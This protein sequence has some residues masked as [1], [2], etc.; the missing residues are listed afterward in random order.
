MGQW[1]VGSL[2]FEAPRTLISLG[3]AISSGGV[4]GFFK[5]GFKK[6]IRKSLNSKGKKTAAQLAAD[7]IRRNKRN[8]VGKRLGA[9]YMGGSATGA[10]ASSF[11]NDV[12]RPFQA[13]FQP[14][15]DG[16]IESW[17]EKLELDILLNPF[18]KKA[19]AAGASNWLLNI[20]KAGATG[21][22]SEMGAEFGSNLNHAIFK[23][24]GLPRLNEVDE[25][26]ARNQI[27]EGLLEA[28]TLGFFMDAGFATAGQVGAGA[29]NKAGKF[30]Q[31]RI[32]AAN[33]PSKENIGN[34]NDALKDVNNQVGAKVAN[35]I[36]FGMLG[37]KYIAIE[38][39]AQGQPKKQVEVPNR[40]KLDELKFYEK[41]NELYKESEK[42]MFFYEE[43]ADGKVKLQATVYD[44]KLLIDFTFPQKPTR[45]GK[46]S[47]KEFFGTTYLDIEKFKK[48]FGKSGK[49]Y[50]TY[51]AFG[52]MIDMLPNTRK[53]KEYAKFVEK[54]RQQYKDILKESPFGVYTD[55]P[56]SGGFFS[57][58]DQSVN[59]NFNQQG[60]IT[61]ETI[62]H[63]SIHATTAPLIYRQLEDLLR[64]DEKARKLFNS[65]GKDSYKGI[66]YLSEKFPETELGQ[67][68]RLMVIAFESQGLD[69][70]ILQRANGTQEAASGIPGVP[71][72]QSLIVE[73]VTETI[74]SRSFQEELASIPMPGKSGTNLFTEFLNLLLRVL[75]FKKDENNLLLE[76]IGLV[77]SISDVTQDK[78]KKFR[79]ENPDDL[80]NA[81]GLP[82]R[83]MRNLDYSTDLRTRTDKEKESLRQRKERIYQRS[84][85]EK[86]RMEL[87]ALGAETLVDMIRNESPIKERAKANL[88]SRDYNVL[89][90]SKDVELLA[91]T[92]LQLDLQQNVKGK[93]SGYQ[94]IERGNF[95][96][97]PGSVV[98]GQR[99]DRR[100]Q[101]KPTYNEIFDNM[102]VLQAFGKPISLP[103]TLNKFKYNKTFLFS[104]EI[105]ELFGETYTILKSEYA[106]NVQAEDMRPGFIVLEGDLTVAD[107][108]AQYEQGNADG[109]VK[110]YFLDKEDKNIPS[111]YKDDMLD[112]VT[113]ALTL[114]E[115]LLKEEQKIRNRIDGV[116]T[117]VEIDDGTYIFLDAPLG[118]FSERAQA[119]LN[120]ANGSTKEGRSGFRGLARRI[121]TPKKWRNV[122][123]RIKELAPKIFIAERRMHQREN[124]Y[125][126]K[127][128]EAFRPF[129]NKFNQITRQLSTK[130]NKGEKGFQYSERDEFNA[131]VLNG[132]WDTVLQ[133]AK[134]KGI[135]ISN[136]IKQIQELYADIAKKLGFPPNVNYFRR[137][138]IDKDA[139]EAYIMNKPTSFIEQLWIRAAKRK[140]AALTT[141]EKRAVI[142]AQLLRGKNA[143]ELL[144]QR[145]IDKVDPF[146]SRFYA[147]PVGRQD[148][149]FTRAAR[150]FAR[151]EF[152]GMKPKTRTLKTDERIEIGKD[153]KGK[154]IYKREKGED[155]KPGPFV[156]QDLT[157]VN[158]DPVLTI[159]DS[160]MTNMVYDNDDVTSLMQDI[161]TDEVFKKLTVDDKNELTKLLKSVLN[162]QPSGKWGSRVRT[163]VSLKS[164]LQLDTILLQLVDVAVSM[165]YNGIPATV[166]AMFSKEQ[167]YNEV[168][169]LATLGLADIGIEAFDV[170]VAENR[171][172]ASKTF[173]GRAQKITDSTLKLAFAP[174]GAMDLF[175]KRTLAMATVR[176]WKD[177][178]VND[179]QTLYRILK[180]K[181]NDDA[182]IQKVI[183]DIANNKASAD[184]KLAF[185][186]EVSEY[187]PITTSDQIQYYIDNKAIRPALVLSSFAF[188]LYSRFG[189]QGIGLLTEGSALLKAGKIDSNE[190]AIEQGKQ[191]IRDGIAGTAKFLIGTLGVEIA[192]R[193]AIKK[194]Y[195][196]ADIAFEEEDDEEAWEN[197]LLI[198]W[199]T[200]ILGLNPLV[201]QYDIKQLLK[202][203]DLGKVYENVISLVP[204]FGLET[205]SSFIKSLL[206][207]EPGINWDDP[208][209]WR[210]LPFA[211]DYL[212]GK[213]VTEEKLREESR[214][215][216]RIKKKEVKPDSKELTL[217]ERITQ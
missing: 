155:G 176:R 127:Y 73:F 163:Y 35:K 20:G 37:D 175:G 27:G 123:A 125:S 164:I 68:C 148:D 102:V 55:H 206:D 42:D 14:I 105:I 71:Y 213:G 134:E 24:K 10:S 3:I 118:E 28:A 191:M 154:P 166:G 41:L 98:G 76:S 130:R 214:R 26:F 144:Q 204:F 38:Y 153:K 180:P 121:L 128:R 31:A 97:Q 187:H 87:V 109:S 217:G 59:Q 190:A 66:K 179:P 57:H 208:K 115:F 196:E 67:L 177:L 43:Q 82:L 93:E 61:I 77:E 44:P 158:G 33:N 178:A 18:Q 29:V 17:S 169:E 149:Y 193:M 202:N 12:T 7:R 54:F 194:A 168:G 170:E 56:G 132:E 124:L 215:R 207:D 195:E 101:Y 39:D 96:V 139:L 95:L 182:F 186:M 8:E 203:K 111:S 100:G 4:L 106:P 85:L 212:Y 90:N 137:D 60:G 9:L 192:I 13:I 210:D 86:R 91:S 162:Y 201:S 205:M 185:F 72:G 211:G 89:I 131:A 181:F 40:T 197:S 65:E 159:E 103:I 147:N 141:E 64:R 199:M 174:L 133:I 49:K 5:Q 81:R 167:M 15:L 173:T 209:L 145:T 79:Q 122:S 165:I 146:A 129:R 50:N 74:S 135:S 19:V 156:Y 143:D 6:E 160:E 63:E 83:T 151:S 104:V 161:L 94:G 150:I 200:A 23:E 110:P 113:K 52:L 184:A 189:T 183:N 112:K 78:V 58:A 84:D 140:G 16:L 51:D 92:Y 157:D 69:S 22:F 99:V 198:E 142:Q 21:S 188:K 11:D 1:I 45:L 80:G 36:V 25:F 30:A 138:V 70:F 107:A 53:G 119:V 108:V 46:P 32:E 126:R 47:G 152:I 2:S 34:L 62:I 120:A 88:D 216:Q 116:E 117:Q 114:E 172:S 136:E 171:A 48:T 75:G